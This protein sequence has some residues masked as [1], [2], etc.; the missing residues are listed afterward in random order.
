MKATNG[1]ARFSS[2]VA[3]MDLSVPGQERIILVEHCRSVV[4]QTNGIEF[5]QGHGWGM[6]GGMQSEYDLD[7]KPVQTAAREFGEE[8]FGDERNDRGIRIVENTVYCEKWEPGSP[9]CVYTF[10]ADARAVTIH[11]FRTSDP[12]IL[13][14]RWFFLRDLP[15]ESRDRG[16]ESKIVIYRTA[17][18]RI[19]AIL[20]LLDKNKLALEILEHAPCKYSV[21]PAVIKALVDLGQTELAD[22]FQRRRESFLGIAPAE[23]DDEDLAL[24]GADLLRLRQDFRQILAELTLNS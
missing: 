20:I 21:S 12:L 16:G 11:P 24:E 8:I 3:A 10:F 2:F 19:L 13:A 17:F 9:Y 5:V 23:L 14:S 1:V 18:A 6:P 22:R 7:E 4:A 15:F